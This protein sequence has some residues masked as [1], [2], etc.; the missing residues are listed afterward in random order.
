MFFV[1]ESAA[2]KYTWSCIHKG[3][4]G[5]IFTMPNIIKDGGS[6]HEKSELLCYFDLNT[7]ESINWTHSYLKLTLEI[8]LFTDI[9]QWLDEVCFILRVI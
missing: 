2:L 6:R 1:L 5:I 3:V 4:E 7:F 9:R 8:K